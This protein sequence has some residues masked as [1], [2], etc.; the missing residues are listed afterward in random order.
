MTFLFIRMTLDDSFITWRY[1]KTLAE[2]GVWNWNSTGPL[3]EAYTNPLYAALSIVPAVLGISAELFF[4]LV[5]IAMVAGY[6]LVV[7]RARL[8]R[9]QEFVL[10]A[11]A[12]A[13]PVF[14][15]QL[16]LGLETASFALLI[17]LLF[18]ILYRRGSLGTAGF[19]VA[20]AV[21][22][23]RP[24]G[25]VLAFVAIAWALVLDRRNRANWIGAVSVLGGWGLY[26]CARWWYFGQFFPNTYYKKTANDESLFVKILDLALVIGPLLL[27]IVLGIAVA[28][29]LYRRQVAISHERPQEILRDATP[30]LLAA[31]SAAVVLGV[32]QKSD[33]VMDPGHR[34]YWQLLFPVV[35]VVLSR[36][37]IRP[38]QTGPDSLLYR[39]LFG[40][41]AVAI[42]TVTVVA[43]H[44]SLSSVAMIV[45]VGVVA[46]AVI[47]GFAR[48]TRVP[49]AIAAIGLATTV[50][51]TST[52]ELT[53]LLAYR[54]R[55]ADAHEAIGK[56]I[57]R[58]QL[59]P[60]S[61]AVGDAG[62]LPYVVDQRVVDVSGLGTVATAHG[63][64]DAEY[65]DEQNLGLVVLISREPVAGT[66]NP[67]DSSPVFYDYVTNERPDFVAGRAAM[68]AD[69][70]Y[71]NYWIS[72]EWADSGLADE[73]D[74][75]FERSKRDNAMPNPAV[76]MDNLWNFPFLR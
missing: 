75:V 55:L 58:T 8:P 68:F 18:S 61:I 36:P 42:A 22:V 48:D 70:Y 44:E 27:P 3:V 9:I 60:G 23:S 17:G 73:L 2:S 14:Y 25:I 56:A 6:V 67:V 32:Y 33:L 71:L 12:L 52:S 5:S 76:F 45:G 20:A 21:A 62:I 54:Y 59:P 39:R 69:K 49:M 34:F 41:I 51:F 19:L 28:A 47:V 24:E 37:I 66:T 65:L 10:L 72:P 43:W 29:T 38:A 31:V 1:G 57:E 46:V 64:V 15:V 30:A 4:K 26:W 35:L 7:R 63:T 53:S 11:V 16:Y 50:G 13:S 74:E 40:L